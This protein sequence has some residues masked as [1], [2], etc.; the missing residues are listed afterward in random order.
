MAADP[1][2][3]WANTGAVAA[4]RSGDVITCA[5]ATTSGDCKWQFL[6]PNVPGGAQVEFRVKA[7]AI[8][9]TPRI[10]ADWRVAANLCGEAAVTDA[11]L[12][13]YTLSFVTPADG[14]TGLLRLRVGVH[15]AAVGVATF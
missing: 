10:F 1:W 9:G 12:Q 6:I 2:F 8:S 7:R 4:T 13:E 15:T 5:D 14:P 11:F 3:G